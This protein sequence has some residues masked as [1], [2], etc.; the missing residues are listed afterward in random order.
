MG[1]GIRMNLRDRGSR[2]VEWVHLV[3]NRHRWQ[4]VV[5]AVMNVRVLEPRS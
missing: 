5:N 2:G 4:A 1:G 3:R